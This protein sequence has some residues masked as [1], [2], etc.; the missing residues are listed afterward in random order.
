MGCF[1]NNP[2]LWPQPSPH[3][4]YVKTPQPECSSG[5]SL[6]DEEKEVLSLLAQAWAAFSEL[7]EKHPSDND[8]FRYAVHLCQQK[9]GMRVA[10]RVDQDIWTQPN[11]DDGES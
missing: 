1:V 7:G 4:C 2:S 5:V 11:K 9:V 10:R 8:E 6:T 3:L